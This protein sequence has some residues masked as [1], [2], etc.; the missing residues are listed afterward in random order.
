MPHSDRKRPT[1]A[2]FRK[3]R[4]GDKFLAKRNGAYFL[5][6]SGQSSFKTNTARES[7][8]QA[9][10]HLIANNKNSFYDHADWRGEIRHETYVH[11]AAS[12]FL[13]WPWRV[14]FTSVPE[15]KNYRTISAGL[16]F[17]YHARRPR[18]F[19]LGLAPLFPGNNNY[20]VT[21]YLVNNYAIAK[22]S[23]AHSSFRWR[24]R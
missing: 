4:C 23:T 10:Y 3:I 22:K 17:I 24:G 6:P 21:C 7:I 2:G 12:V 8:E 5:T 14:V 15:N 9:F 11:A 16:P 1:K 20:L 13:F 18:G 19:R